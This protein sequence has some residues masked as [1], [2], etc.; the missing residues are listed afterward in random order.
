MDKDLK[1]L[2]SRVEITDGCWLWKGAGVKYG[3]F[4]FAGANESAHKVSYMLHKG[5]IP[6]GMQVCHT[7]DHPKCVNPEHLF[8]GTAK[9]NAQDR[10]RK[11]R[12]RKQH[13]ELQEMS[14]LSNEQVRELRRSYKTGEVSQASLARYY[15]V[16]PTTVHDIVHNRIYKEELINE[17]K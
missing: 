11:D 2:L 5:D 16:S 13:G 1:R 15:S 4:W 17:S 12:N 10:V 14:K 8:L 9:D 3:V 6:L 7:C